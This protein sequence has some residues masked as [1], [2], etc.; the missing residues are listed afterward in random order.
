MKVYKVL[1]IVDSFSPNGDGINDCWYIKNIDNYPKA[2]VS[3]FSRYGQRVFQSIGYSKPW[4][5]RFN[6]AYLPAGTYY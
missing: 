6:G 5:G 3:V 1:T 4:D 2:D